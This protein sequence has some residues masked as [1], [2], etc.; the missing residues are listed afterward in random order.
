MIQVMRIAMIWFEFVLLRG[1]DWPSLQPGYKTMDET[2]VEVG[3]LALIP[4]D[5]N[6][7]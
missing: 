5:T 1:Q 6:S 4:L 7:P 3:L 2:Q